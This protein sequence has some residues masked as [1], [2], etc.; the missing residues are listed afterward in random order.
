M[1]YYSPIKNQI[2]INATTWMNHEN[3]RERSQKQKAVYTWFYFY[4]M[5]R[6]GG[7]IEIESRRMGDRGLEERREE[8]DS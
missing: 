5:S 4:E 7:S 8:R 3:V 2:P 1:E 6:V